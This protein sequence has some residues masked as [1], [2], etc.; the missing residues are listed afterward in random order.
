MSAIRVLPDTLINQI[1]AGE[2][3]DRPASALKEL[4]E[5]SLDAGAHDIRVDLTEG[6]TRLIRVADEGCGI[7]RSE[8]ALA[9]ARH[10]TS[11]ITSLRDL[12]QVASLGFRGE[13]LSSIAAIARVALSSRRTSDAHGWRILCE[14]GALEE[15]VPSPQVAGTT[16]EVTD[17]YF[18][19][20]ARRK[21]LKSEATEYGH[22]EEAF[23]RIA[24][25]RSAVAFSLSH[26]GKARW[27][28]KRQEFSERARSL[29]GEEFYQA[30]VGIDE[31]AADLRL[32][33]LAARPDY[34]RTTR[35][36]QYFYVNGRF[37][38]DR[39]LTHAV[40]QAYQDV[41]HHDRQPAY[42]LALELPPAG[43]DVNVH[44]SKI[45]VRFR[46]SR[47]VH[48]F[49][50]HAVQRAVTQSRLAAE[51]LAQP[52]TPHVPA[53][54]WSSVGG[55]VGQAQAESP[56]L[57]SA[58]AQ[59]LL[60]LAAAQ[61]VQRYETLFRREHGGD[62]GAEPN[63]EIPPLGF[64]LAQLAGVYILA[65]RATGLVI[66]DMHAAHERIVYERLKRTLEESAVASQPLLVPVAFAADALDIATADEYAEQLRRIGFEIAVV[67]PGALA[68]R[69]IP[70]LLREA[71]AKRLALDVL[72]EM[73]D[74]GAER[75]LAERRNELLATMACHAAV[76]ANRA[77][78]LAEMNALLREM[79]AADRSDYCNHGRP[80]WFELPMAELDARFMRGR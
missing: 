18:N 23:R 10:A 4:L 76:R 21:F 33:G 78:T 35:D 6:G 47:A 49:V 26:N 34:S 77:L 39:L 48:Q 29:L 80:T 15:P 28:L 62:T 70:A 42:I 37:V 75:V 12:E 32:H 66:V 1:A 2:V 52:G 17:L 71:D 63:E 20:P 30:S 43:V 8:L 54:S 79:E 13:A 7:D 65:Q 50:L 40:R 27:L 45:E 59:S 72:H 58:G 36:V 9:L 64:A 67:G 14:G 57:R 3:V 25:A 68:V 73:R 31:A 41:L 53:R 60:P 55:S 69:A 11:K 5:N 19:T 56:I 61:S 16:V 22:C 44:P 38:R 74:Y 51:P 24:L 46:D